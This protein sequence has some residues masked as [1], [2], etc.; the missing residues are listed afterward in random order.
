MN[1]NTPYHN[2]DGGLAVNPIFDG[3]VVESNK[4]YGYVLVKHSTPIKLDDGTVLTEYYSGYM[5]MTNITA[6]GTKVTKS[7]TL[8]NIS[9]VSPDNTTEHLHF[10]VYSGT[11]TKGG[12]KS[13]NVKTKLYIGSKIWWFLVSRRNL[14]NN[15]IIERGKKWEFSELPNKSIAIDGACGKKYNR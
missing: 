13:I 14:M 2:K 7:T 5:H 12:L 10:I 9:N 1:L 15:I 4:T 3:E 6:K 8:G 11:N